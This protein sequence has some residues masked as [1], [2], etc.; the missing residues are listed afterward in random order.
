MRD[1]GQQVEVISCP[2]NFLTF[3][4]Q[5]SKQGQAAGLCLPSMVA[6]PGR[7]PGRRFFT[8]Q[9]LY[10]SLWGLQH[11]AR[12]PPIT[13]LQSFAKTFPGLCITCL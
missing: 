9:F 10:R 6:G 2:V 3:F 12:I 7:R 11:C 13:V 8:L 1:R 5:A 4:F